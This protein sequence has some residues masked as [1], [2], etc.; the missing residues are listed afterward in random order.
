MLIWGDI[1]LNTKSK[2][3]NPIKQNYRLKEYIGWCT[4]FLFPFALMGVTEVTGIGLAAVLIYIGASGFFLRKVIENKIPYFNPRF[5]GIHY[6]L[7]S[8]VA[9]LS[10]FAYTLF[11]NHGLESY[12]YEQIVLIIIFF[13]IIKGL[14]EQ[15]IMVNIFDLVGC[16]IK[17]PGYIGVALNTIF[18]YVL[19]WNKFIIASAWNSS[20]IIFFQLVL[21]FISIN[22]Y[23]KT[24]D[25]T[26]CSVF[27]ILFNVIIVLSCGFNINLY[28]AL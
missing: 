23:F 11:T 4:V 6:E 3:T 12:A 28:L 25:T 18:M 13:A 16:K 7:F 10:A 9:A 20:V 1:I 5:N 19:F 17:L 14:T 8:A 22:I 27:Q 26:I 21:T 15:L 2:N 24:K